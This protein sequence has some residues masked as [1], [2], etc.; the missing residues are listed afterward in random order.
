[1]VSNCSLVHVCISTIDS[2]PLRNPFL[3]EHCQ[4]CN[5]GDSIAGST[6]SVRKV[7]SHFKYLFSS[8]IQPVRGRLAKHAGTV[9]P[10]NGFIYSVTITFTLAELADLQ[11]CIY[12][13]LV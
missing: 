5:I 4:Y 6:R 13:G 9:T 12:F 3:N 7:S 1:M 11:V 10:L 8:I 2:N